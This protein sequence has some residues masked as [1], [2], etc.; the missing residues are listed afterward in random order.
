MKYVTAVL[1]FLASLNLAIAQDD[2]STPVTPTMCALAQGEAC[3]IER[4]TGKTNPI[5]CAVHCTVSAQIN[6]GALVVDPLAP[7]ET[8]LSELTTINLL[9]QEIRICSASRLFSA[10]GIAEAEVLECLSYN[11]TDPPDCTGTTT[12]PGCG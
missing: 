4:C 5:V 10:R 3:A 12:G 8:P 2:D 1:I 6:C 7:H 11:P 9:T